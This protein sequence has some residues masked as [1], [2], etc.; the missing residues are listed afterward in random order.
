MVNFNYPYRIGE[1][2]FTSTASRDKHI[3]DMLEQILFTN[4]GERAH[5]PEFGSGI[6]E[7]LFTENT[8]ELAASIQHMVQGALQQWLSGEI[9]VLEVG[10]Q[11]E[12]NKL[13]VLVR[14]R[15]L[16]EEAEQTISLTREL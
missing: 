7:M 8:P 1:D 11:S 9:Q 6:R 3:R 12:A 2:G 4:R 13:K 14:Y 15:P 16:N 10:V 5:R